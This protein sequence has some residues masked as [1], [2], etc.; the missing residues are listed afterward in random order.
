MLD[1]RTQYS[2]VHYYILKSS[3]LRLVYNIPISCFLFCPSTYQQSGRQQKQQTKQSFISPMFVRGQMWWYC[4]ICLDHRQQI[5]IYVSLRTPSQKPLI[6]HRGTSKLF[7][8]H[9]HQRNDRHINTLILY[10]HD[11][12]RLQYIK[13]HSHIM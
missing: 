13:Y 12:D 3:R 10:I 11:Y 4:C 1:V 6:N 9:K 7:T 2:N 5:W 8:L